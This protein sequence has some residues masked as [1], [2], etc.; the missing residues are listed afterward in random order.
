MKVFIQKMC[1]E[2]IL[3]CTKVLWSTAKWGK[4]EEITDDTW[5]IMAVIKNED[6]I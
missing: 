2:F 6:K 5:I 3:L 1:S 4:I